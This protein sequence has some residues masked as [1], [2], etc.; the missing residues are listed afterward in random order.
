MCNLSKQKIARPFQVPPDTT[1]FSL[2]TLAKKLSFSQ[3]SLFWASWLVSETET[4]R[5]LALGM[6]ICSKVILLPSDFSL[7]S[8]SPTKAK[9]CAES[10]AIGKRTAPSWRFTFSQKCALRMWHCSLNPTTR[11]TVLECS[12]AIMC[13]NWYRI[14]S[15]V[16]ERERKP[17]TISFSI[18]VFKLSPGLHH[19]HGNSIF[20]GGGVNCSLRRLLV[21]WQCPS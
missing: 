5:R 15:I 3:S 16:T 14:I 19:L 7:S 10:H 12:G 4:R 13:E 9:C 11:R 1:C 17:H 8:R 20:T 21:H 6:A 18:L 2:T